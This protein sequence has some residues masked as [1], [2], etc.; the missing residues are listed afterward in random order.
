MQKPFYMQ[1]IICASLVL[2]ACGA[3]K[4]TF[5]IDDE[6]FS[7]TWAS[8]TP[9]P[10]K[11]SDLTATTVGDAIYLI[12]GCDSDQEWNAGAGMYLCTGLS[13]KVEKYVPK[14]DSYETLNDAPRSRYR[15]TAAALGSKI[16]VLGGC[17]IDDSI[18]TEVDVLD[19]LTGQ[20]STLDYPMP[21]ATSDLSSFVSDEKIYAV[22]GYN[23][24][25]YLASSAMLIFDPKQMGA[26]AWI[27]G[28]SLISG[29]GDAAAGLAGGQAFVLG[30]FHHDNWS[31]PRD[32]LEIFDP[33]RPSAGWRKRQSMSV[34][35]GDK[36]V[37]VIH[38]LLHVVGGETKNAAKQS[39]ALMDVEV[40]HVSKDRWYAGGSIPSHRFRFVA[41][42][43][44]HSIFIFGGQ[45]SLSGSYGAAGSSYPVLDVVD[46]Y[47]EKHQSLISSAPDQGVLY[48][49]QLLLLEAISL[50]AFQSI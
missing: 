20:W 46:E 5:I 24:P 16:Y 21:N 12:G 18:I 39:V 10:S 32:D 43:F 7:H 17:G 42:A 22:G 25:D 44:D 11:R 41:A 50:L 31:Y 4:D 45:G 15:H 2:A 26:A 30:G 48:T 1:C 36:A 23:R 6:E 14:S 37:A 35:R 33:A 13:K 38:D 9:M 34:A 28:Q 3:S 29:R 19:T 49:W 8:K 40:Y 27:A 47:E